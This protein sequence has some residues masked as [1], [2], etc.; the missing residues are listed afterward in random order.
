MM[1][2]AEAEYKGLPSTFS[3]PENIHECFD[4]NFADDRELLKNLEMMNDE[5]FTE[6]KLVRKFFTAYFVSFG[7]AVACVI[8][9]LIMVL[10]KKTPC[11]DSYL[12]VCAD[13]FLYYRV[14]N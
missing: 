7:T 1:N 9:G 3:M 6:M 4:Y 12:S 14:F 13:F 10:Y 5:I 2:A 11:C 8:V